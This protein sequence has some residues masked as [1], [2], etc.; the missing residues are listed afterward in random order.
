MS[1]LWR[2]STLIASSISTSRGAQTLFVPDGIL[3]HYHE[4]NGRPHGGDGDDYAGRFRE[5]CRRK[6]K[7]A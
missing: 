1:L 4:G 2:Y 6:E 5:V 3:L 7:N